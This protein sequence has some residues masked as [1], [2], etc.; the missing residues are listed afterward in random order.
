MDWKIKYIFF[1]FLFFFLSIKWRGSKGL[2]KNKNPSVCIHTAAVNIQST[3]NVF[4]IY[5]MT[6]VAWHAFIP[7]S[8]SPNFIFFSKNE[9]YQNGIYSYFSSKIDKYHSWI[10]IFLQKKNPFLLFTECNPSGLIRHENYS[11]QF[12]TISEFIQT[13]IWFIFSIYYIFIKRE[14][15]NLDKV[16]IKPPPLASSAHEN[17]L[18]L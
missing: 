1:L 8:L 9:I 18:C 15:K 10:V 4:G 5:H 11:P 6:R 13:C 14:V 7:L 17:I 16:W 2:L 3:K 12:F